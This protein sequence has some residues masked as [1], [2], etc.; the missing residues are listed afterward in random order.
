MIVEP[1]EENLIAEARLLAAKEHAWNRASAMG[2]CPRRLG[3]QKL[4]IPGMPLT[5]RRSL[6]LRH[7]TVFDIGLKQ[8]IK[9]ALG[10]RFLDGDSLPP[11]KVM[12]EGIEITGSFDGVFQM[13]DGRLAVVEIKTCAG[14]TFEQAQQGQVD[15]AYLAQAWVYSE[16]TGCPVVVFIFYRKETSH[17]CEVIFDRDATETV[18]TKRFGGNELEIATK[19]PALIAEVRT[20]FDT[21]ISDR[22]KKTIIEVAATSSLIQLPEGVRAI[23]PELYKVQGKA[24]AEEAAK[25]YG[26]G[27]QAGSWWIF[28]TKRQIAGFPCSYCPWIDQCLGATLEIKDRRPLWIIPKEVPSVAS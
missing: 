24:K 15:I 13:D 18:I 4:G 8:D 3:Y 11:D 17:L 19:D 16:M 22:V 7:G 1:L 28:E 21:S 9:Q 12:I 6:V 5:P 27:W 25:I 20:P 10:H 14:R 2:Y 23:E 26:A